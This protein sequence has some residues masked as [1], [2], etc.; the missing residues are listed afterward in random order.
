VFVLSVV[1]DVPVD[2]RQ[3]DACGDFVNLE[4]LSAQSSKI[5]LGVG[6]ARMCS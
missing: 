1:G 2:R 4:N 3:R 5:L 6:F